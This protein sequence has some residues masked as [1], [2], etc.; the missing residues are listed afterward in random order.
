MALDPNVFL[1]MIKNVARSVARQF[2]PYV[3]SDDC[4][5]H[6]TVW[7]YEK[8][9]SV[10][11]AVEESPSD[12]EPKIASTMRKVAFDYC[13]REKADTEGYSVDDLYRYS[14]PKIKSLL[15]DVF[16][17]ADWQ[18][19][20]QVSD[21]QPRSRG[22]ANQTG[23]RIAELADVKSAVERLPHDTKEL[24]YYQYVH[25]YTVENLAEHFDIGLEAAKKRAQRAVGA[26]QKEL[27]RKPYEEQ[28]KAPQ[29]R[30]VKSN[31]AW[32]SMNSTQWDG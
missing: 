24:L 11:K 3:T 2:P 4:E 6:L 16:S 7:L 22:L 17:Y 12:W 27:G 19:F 20:G 15:E 18:T 9:A 14:V 29:R 28:P 30:T 23:D 10:L 21:G 5:Q 8:R 32:Q 13:A 26:I 25:Q 31:A 1:P